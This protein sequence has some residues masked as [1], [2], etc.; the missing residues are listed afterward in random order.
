MKRLLMMAFSIGIFSFGSASCSPDIPVESPLT[1][2]PGTPAEPDHPGNSENNGNTMN[3]KLRITVGA[4]SFTVTLYD[5]AAVAVFRTMLP[6]TINMKEM[7]GNEKLYYLP[8]R[9]PTAASYPATIHAGDLMLWG[10]DCLVLF[11]KS[12]STSYNYTRLGRVD[13]AAG[14]ETAVGS[15]SVTVTF[16]QTETGKIEID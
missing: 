12:F 6:M 15:G 11:Y 2:R 9:L 13:D 3:N 16:E 7:N 4:A 1:A 10:S 5:N 8:G 14:L